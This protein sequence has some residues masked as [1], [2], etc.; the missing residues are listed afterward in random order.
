MSST[1]TGDHNDDLQAFY[2]HVE[3]Y[4]YHHHHKVINSIRSPVNIGK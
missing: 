2:H 1:H 3:Y 4:H